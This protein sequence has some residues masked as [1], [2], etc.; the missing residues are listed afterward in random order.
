ML[1]AY[2]NGTI[3]AEESAGS[4]PLVVA[5][6]GWGRSRADLLPLVQGRYSIAVDLPGFGSSP[7]PSTAWGSAEYASALEATIGEIAPGC[8]VIVVGH[9]FGGRVAVQLAAARPDLVNGLVLSGVPLLRASS[10]AKAPIGYRVIRRARSWRL[11]SQSRLDQA[12][13][14]FGSADYRAA[15]GVMRDVLVRVVNE[16]YES[17]LRSI[18]CPVGFCWGALDTAAPLSVAE[19]ASKLV[20]RI[21]VFKVS[22]RS[23]HDV[24]RQDPDLFRGT[25]DTIVRAI[26]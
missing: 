7:P 15:Q 12:R 19:D 21:E 20:R 8:A 26:S 3:F 10:G 1:R 25:I 4:P 9:S 23:G 17:Q 2:V 11:V 6:H 13:N 5:L 18:E 24:H 22:E 16:S 14:R